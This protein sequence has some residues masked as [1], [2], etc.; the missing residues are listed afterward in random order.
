M[1]NIEN[2]SYIKKINTATRLKGYK[3]DEGH[4]CIIPK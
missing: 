1:N 3:F 2:K 4:D